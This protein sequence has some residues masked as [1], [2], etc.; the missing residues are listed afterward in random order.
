MLRG[1]LGGIVLVTGDGDFCHLAHY[2]REQRIPLHCIGT[3]DLSR[4]LRKA[5]QSYS[6]VSPPCPPAP[7]LIP[8]PS[9]PAIPVPITPVAIDRAAPT[10]PAPAVKA[11]HIVKN[12]TLYTT[13]HHILSQEKNGTLTMMDLNKRMATALPGADLPQS[14]GGRN[15]TQWL[16]AQS[17]SFVIQGNGT[18]RYVRAAP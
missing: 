10:T 17:G 12:Q 4:R 15:W 7:V 2:L 16:N 5:A 13:L 9:A 8:A 3:E 14:R 1:S 11:L 6:I 18:A